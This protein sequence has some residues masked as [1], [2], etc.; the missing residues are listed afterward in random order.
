MYVSNDSKSVQCACE[1]LGKIPQYKCQ[2]AE[3]SGYK[4][5]MRVRQ[6][7]LTR[8]IYAY[9]VLYCHLNLNLT[10]RNR[11]GRPVHSICSYKERWDFDYVSKNSERNQKNSEKTENCRKK[12]GYNLILFERVNKYFPD[13][14]K[15]SLLVKNL[16]FLFYPNKTWSN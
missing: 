12:F 9:S 8:L 4:R 1:H 16:Q 15:K 2:A 6:H 11:T 10:R 7:A 13:W 3:F 5:S 14:P